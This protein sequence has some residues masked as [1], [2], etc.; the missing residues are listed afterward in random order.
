[1]SIEYFMNRPLKVNFS[2]LCVFLLYNPDFYGGYEY[3]YSFF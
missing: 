1:M 2:S 3:I